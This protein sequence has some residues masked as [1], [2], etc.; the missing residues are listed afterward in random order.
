MIVRLKSLLLVVSNLFIIIG[1]DNNEKKTPKNLTPQHNS[2]S[3]TL[4][5]TTE[6]IIHKVAQPTPTRLTYSIPLSPYP[7]GSNFSRNY[8]N[9]NT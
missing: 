6:W 1:T 2:I 3:L 7:Q 9:K 4:N 8:H 5:Y